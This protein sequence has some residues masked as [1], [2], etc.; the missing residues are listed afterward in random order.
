MNENEIQFLSESNAIEGVYDSDSLDQA[1]EAWKFLM[2]KDVLTHDVILKTHKILMLHTNLQP[3]EKGYFRQC[4][5]RIGHRFGLNSS[6]V[7]SAM[8]KWI[9]ESMR[10][11]PKVD[12][13]KLHVEFEMIH[14]FVDGNGRV[15]RMLYNWT[16]IKRNEEPLH[17]IK[18]EDRQEYYKWFH[19]E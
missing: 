18:E 7:P 10:K 14:P 3:D 15:G 9:F 4:E 11:H 19:E 6:L 2:S 5:V 12:A 1:I 16:R 8:F 17:I 13:K